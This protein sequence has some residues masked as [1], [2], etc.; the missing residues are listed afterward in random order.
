MLNL[1]RVS[2]Q[3]DEEVGDGWGDGWGC[4]LSSNGNVLNYST[5]PV[6]IVTMINFIFHVFFGN[7]SINKNTQADSL[8][9]SVIV[10][11]GKLP[12]CYGN[13]PLV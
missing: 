9:A 13:I 6:K 3:G 10:K 8:I 4:W 7:E 12:C 11:K 1:D 5:G 2:A